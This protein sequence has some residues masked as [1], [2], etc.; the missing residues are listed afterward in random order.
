MSTPLKQPRD[1]PE[2][3]SALMHLI[4]AE[5]VSVAKAAELFGRSETAIRLWCSTLPIS[6][7]I[8]GGS[9]VISLG[10]RA[11]EMGNPS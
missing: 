9:H 6:C 3:P 1:R 5:S 2:M 4:R 10:R 7:R 11:Y 8:G